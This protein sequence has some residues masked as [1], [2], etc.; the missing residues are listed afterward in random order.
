[1][2]KGLSHAVR[3]EGFFCRDSSFARVTLNKMYYYFL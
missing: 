1:M 2:K 3:D